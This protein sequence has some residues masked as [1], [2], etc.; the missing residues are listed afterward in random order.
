MRRKDKRMT[1]DR[2]YLCLK[3]CGVV[4]IGFNDRE[5]PYIVPMNFGYENI[6][7]RDILYMHCAV[8]GKKLDLMN[9]NPNVGFEMD[10]DYGITHM[11][12]PSECSTNYA[13][14]IGTGVLEKVESYSEKISALSI[15]MKS[16][17]EREVQI[18][19]KR[20]VDK[21]TI[22]KL[23]IKNMTGKLSMDLNTAEE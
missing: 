18:F 16:L 3:Q 21:T 9:T 10:I 20:I 1:K 5:Y 13:S 19:D 2:L 7:G 22:L 11:D 14:I 4:R 17:T 12:N 15:L 8:E 23:V 6:D